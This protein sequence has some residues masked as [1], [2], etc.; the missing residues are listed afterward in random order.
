MKLMRNIQEK[1]TGLIGAISR[2]PLTMVFLLAIAAVNMLSINN[3]FEQYSTY[4]FTFIVGGLLSAVGQQMYERYFAHRTHRLLLMGGAITIT[5][6]YYFTIASASSITVENGTKTA[7]IM[8]ALFMTFIWVPSIKNT[9]TFNDSFLATFKALFTTVLFTAVIAGGVSIIITAIDQLLFTVHYNT[10]PHALNLIV[11]L[12]A[13]I[14]FLSLTPNYPGKHDE[15]KTA[16]ELA[17]RDDIVNKATSCP[18]NLGVLISYIIIPLTVVYT[19]ILLFYVVLNIRG[20]FW[21]R[22]LLEP[23]LVSYAITVIIVYILASNIENRF[24]I[25]FRKIFPKVLIPIVLFQTIASILK[26]SEMGVTH[27]RYYVIMFG[28]FA[29][30]A[31]ILFSFSQPEKNGFIVA[32][33]LAFSAIS[34]TPPIDAFTVSKANQIRLLEDTLVKNNMLENNEVVPNSKISAKDKQLITRTVGYLNSMDLMD[35]INWLPNNIFNFDNFYQTFGFNETYDVNNPPDGVGPY[36]KYQYFHLDEDVVLNIEGYDV[37]TV[38]HLFSSEIGLTGHKIAFEKDGVG[39]TIKQQPNG[40]KGT[41]DVLTDKEER[42]I[43]FDMKKIFDAMFGDNQDDNERK[44]N[45]LTIEQATFTEEN[46]QAKLTI[47]IKSIDVH[48]SDYNTEFYV[49]LKIK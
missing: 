12:F 29:L 37:M 2:Y 10:I 33:L 25:L 13:P 41:I 32:V 28:V 42:I 47:L 27:G 19:V 22:N 20:D 7:V 16:E 45:K 1:L 39:Y 36:N 4:L 48:G 46:D 5:I 21:T 17:L 49:L 18:K 24:T 8:F 40:D 38:M 34:I 3:D 23:L 6:I 30:F 14:F 26:I 31:G 9:I 44:D 11:S 35:E 15:G 43:H